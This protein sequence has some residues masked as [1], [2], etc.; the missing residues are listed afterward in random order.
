V[1]FQN[2]VRRRLPHL[3]AL[4][5]KDRVERVGEL[6]VTIPNKEAERCG[7]LQELMEVMAPGVV[8]I[9]DGGGVASAALAPIHGAEAVATV[10]THASRFEFASTITWLNGA[11]AGL[12]EVAGEPAAV[13]VVVD[14]G[15]V[16]RVY[17]VRNLRKLTR[18]H[19][20]ADLAR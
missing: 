18:L 6:A 5:S 17:L 13:S 8:M 20:P 10:L 11:L 1:G 19:E 4:G 7:Q 3:D 2:W 15:R 16:T 12:I 14:N 9:A